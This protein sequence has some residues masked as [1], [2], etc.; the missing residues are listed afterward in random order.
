MADGAFAYPVFLDL[1]DRLVVVVGAGSVG[2]R[3][4]AGLCQAGARVR[5]VDPLLNSADYPHG[6]EAIR[7]CFEPT[8]LAGAQ[9]VFACTDSDQVN[10]SVAEAASS[11][12]L[13]CCRGDQTE[14]SD[15]ALPALLRRGDLTLAVSTGGASPLLAAGIR[16]RLE[17]LIP[18]SWE[19]AVELMAAIRR[20][21]LTATYEK[22]YTYQVLSNLLK[23][24]LLPLLEQENYCEIDRLLQD[25]FGREFSLQRLQVIQPERAL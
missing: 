22:K 5:L 25:T 24:Q 13:W 4:L 21:L 8:D 14:G 20:K 7:R 18:E 6:V 10:R 15:F 16:D 17:E 12:G 3:K 1:H 19:V 9:L 11:Q 23:N 2:R